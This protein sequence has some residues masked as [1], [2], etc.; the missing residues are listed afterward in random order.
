ML[1]DYSILIDRDVSELLSL[2]QRLRQAQKMQ[3]IGTLAGG[4]AHDF[5]NLLTAI[6]GSLELVQDLEPP[7]DASVARLYENAM[8]A[9]RRGA[10]LTRKLLDFSRP[11]HLV[12]QRVDMH[13]VL[14]NLQNFMKQGKVPEEIRGAL[15]TTR[16]EGLSRLSSGRF[17]ITS[18]QRRVGEQCWSLL[19]PS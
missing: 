5:N 12:C 6:Q 3:A 15:D 11:R 7:R 16:L 10:V 8:E 18:E 1:S 17:S 13:D 9:A 14:E 19:S 4:I 2:E